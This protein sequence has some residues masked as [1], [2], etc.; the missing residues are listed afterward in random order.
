MIWKVRVKNQ[1]F[2]IVKSF[3]TDLTYLHKEVKNKNRTNRR[4]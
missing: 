1:S 2:D 3:I 4:S